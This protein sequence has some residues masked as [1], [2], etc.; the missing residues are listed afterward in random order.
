MKNRKILLGLALAAALIMTATLAFAGPH[1]RPHHHHGMFPPMG[2][3]GIYGTPQHLYVLAGCKI[4]QYNLPDLKLL[5]SIDLPKPVPP[6]AAPPGQVQG[7]KP[8]PPPMA[9]AQ[10]FWGSNKALY[11]LAG[12]MLYQYSLPDL[13]LKNKVEL[14]KPKPPKPAPPKADF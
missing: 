1:H 8:P 7:H 14:P 11:V 4:M 5:K 13:T 3:S 10:A 9:G 6:A 12:P 2:V